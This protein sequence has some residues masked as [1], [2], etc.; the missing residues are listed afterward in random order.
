MTNER[1]IFELTEEET[2]R[3]FAWARPLTEAHINADCEPPGAT[4]TFE[5][6]S[7][8][9]DISVDYCGQRFVIREES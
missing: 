3:Y 5:C 2:E 8:F 1:L 9:T 6:C 4:F 7:T